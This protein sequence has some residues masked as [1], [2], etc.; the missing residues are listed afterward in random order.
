MKYLFMDQYGSGFTVR[1]M[2]RV[3]GVSRSGYYRYLRRGLSRRHEEARSLLTKIREIWE[4]SRKVYGSPRVTAELRAQG[5]LCG[6]NR[7]AR[8][9]RQNGIASLT[10]RRYKI[11]T[12]SDHKL[13]V[14]EDLVGRDF[15]AS[16]PNRLWA[17]DI[18][19]IWTWEGW[20]Y[21]AAVMDVYNRE[22][23]GWTLYKRMTKELVANALLKALEKRDPEP[24]LI[25]H[26][27]RGSQYASH[28]VRSILNAW[29]IHQSMS[30]KGDCFDNAI[31]ESFFSSLKKELVHLR[32]FHSRSQAKSYVFDYIEIFYNRQ[33][34]HS[35]L[36]YKT[37]LEYYHEAQA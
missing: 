33:R 9:M 26:S 28:R 20:L 12:S 34:R 7:I 13:P 19:Y 14:A 3:L 15:T 6:E 37:P 23:V 2:C 27:D 11:T 21:L 32:T 36:N 22:I 5:V 17:S 8:I 35:A 29:Q 30:S 25:F 31:M 24:G 18:T 10:R 16:A 1:K 4:G